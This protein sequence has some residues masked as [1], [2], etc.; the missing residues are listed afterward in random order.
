MSS[1]SASALFALEEQGGRSAPTVARKMRYG[2][3]APR[4]RAHG[5]AAAGFRPLLDEMRAG[6]RT[7]CA[8]SAPTDIAPRR[9][10]RENVHPIRLAAPDRGGAISKTSSSR[11]LQMEADSLQIRSARR[12]D[13]EPISELLAQLGYRTGREGLSARMASF[14]EDPCSAL[15]VALKDD[16]VVGLVAFSFVQVLHDPRPW[17]RISVLVVD[18]RWRARGV[19]RS[20]LFAAERAARA[21]GCG[22]IEAT[23][24]NDRLDA[25]RFYEGLGYRRLSAHF[26]KRI[27]E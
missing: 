13:V 21:A 18:E 11:P 3:E 15:L 23:S 16:D 10:E 25:H 22:R 7:G 26:L 8:P 12:D 27:E 19:G 4:G 17:C 5:P 24:A 20:L 2:Y 6:L 1:V 9:A 14:A